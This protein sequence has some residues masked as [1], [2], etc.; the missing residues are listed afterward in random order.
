MTPAGPPPP[1]SPQRYTPL[2]HAWRERAFSEPH[3][4]LLETAL[5]SQEHPRSFLFTAPEQVLAAASPEEIGPLFERIHAALAAGKYVAGWFAYELGYIFQDL[6]CR[7]AGTPLALLGI[8]AAPAIFDHL[9]APGST[10]ELAESP[11]DSLPLALML[12]TS[13]ETYTK[14][15]SEVR[16]WIASGD[17]YQVNYT[18]RASSQ[19]STAPDQM[20]DSLLRQQPCAYAAAVRLNPSQTVL[21]FSPELFFRMDS[22]GNITARPMK[23]TAPR[24]LSPADDARNVLALQ[25]DEKTAAEHVMI[26]DLLRND[27]GRICVTGSVRVPDLFTVERYPSLLQ[28]TSSVCGRLRKGLHPREIF[29]ALFPCGSVTGAPKHHTMELIHRIE[30]TPRGIYTGSIGYFAPNGEA[31][32]NVAIRTAVLEHGRLSMGTGSGIVADSSAEAEYRECLLKLQ[33]TERASE[34]LSLFETMRWDRGCALLPLHLD[35]LQQSAKALGFIYDRSKAEDLLSDPR[36]ARPGPHRRRLTLNRS[37]D[38]DLREAPLTPWREALRVR[39]STSVLQSDD[40]A[41]QHKT[42]FRRVYDDEYNATLAAGYDE[43]LF[44][45]ER[46]EITEGSISSLL[47]E[48]DRLLVTPPRGSGVLPGVFRQALLD[49]QVLRER[50]LTLEDVL[51]AEAVYLCNAVRGAAPVSSLAIGKRTHRLR[52]S[53]FPYP[54]W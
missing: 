39:L 3:A 31:C 32:L 29:E 22:S 17:T 14:T 21:S 9:E 26:V 13:P 35:R 49:C 8:F 5:A 40:P 46:G 50:V 12:H 42:S 38:L 51:R 18:L 45:N 1:S 43:V 7:H 30:P 37:G 27:L 34:P 36:H 11:S 28:M 33:F 6:P 44:L 10:T 48:I 16:D 2:P 25:A 20:Y 53:P 24:G 19:S 54:L 52:A 23:G 15:L 41:L 47:V 4:V